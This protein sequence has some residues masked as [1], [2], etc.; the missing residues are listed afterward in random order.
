VVALLGAG[1]GGPPA[2]RW[3]RRPFAFGPALAIPAEPYHRIGGH[4]AVRTAIADD[5]A[6][7]VVADR[8]GVEVRTLLAGP[9]AAYRM[10]PW[11]L[12]QLVE[13]WTKNLATG[14][15]ATPP[16]RAAA[17]AVWVTAALRSG[18]ALAGGLAGSGDALPAAV[19]AYVLFAV[20]FH[21]VSRRI[22]RFGPTASVLFPL[23]LAAFVALFLWSA[24]LTF[25]RGRVR[26]RGRT[27]E[28]RRAP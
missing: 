25:G 2:R 21:V 15:V 8:H 27:V 28:L 9:L 1:T 6:L 23:V 11:G 13:G 5:V 7:A 19:V 4:A 10:Y 14:G 22:G 24:V 16:L 3:W 20:Q 12:G 17:V 18:L 26:W